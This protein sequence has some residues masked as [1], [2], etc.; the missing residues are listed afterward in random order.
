MAVLFAAPILLD[1][2]DAS[3]ALL[4]Q[5]MVEQMSNCPAH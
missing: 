5:M 3:D 4:Q 2:H 1:P